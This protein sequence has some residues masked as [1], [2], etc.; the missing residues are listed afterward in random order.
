[1]SSLEMLALLEMAQGRPLIHG[2]ELRGQERD[3]AFSRRES[4]RLA[5]RWLIGFGK[6]SLLVLALLALWEVV[7][8]LG[9]PTRHFCRRFPM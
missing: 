1:M 3:Q 7:P 4:L 8:R 6:R 2:Q 9:W 5:G